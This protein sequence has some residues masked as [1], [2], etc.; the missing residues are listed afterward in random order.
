MD[1]KYYMNIIDSSYKDGM[2]ILYEVINVIEYTGIRLQFII[3]HFT[4]VIFNWRLFSNIGIVF[5]FEEDIF[6]LGLFQVV[7]SLLNWI[8]FLFVK[9]KT[10]Y[11]QLMYINTS[12]LAVYGGTRMLLHLE[13]GLV[14]YTIFCALTSWMSY[15]I[16][17]LLLEMKPE[18]KIGKK[19]PIVEETIVVEDEILIEEKTLVE[20]KE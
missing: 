14:W 16:I 2:R 9:N 20:E 11:R 18:L 7:G 4:S 10:P 8:V 17:Y 1:N 15:V 3:L 12:S 5:G 13:M 6:M 19:L